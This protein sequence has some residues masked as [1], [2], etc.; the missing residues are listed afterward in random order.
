MA[1]PIGTPLCCWN[2]T[3]EH[4]SQSQALLEQPNHPFKSLNYTNRFKNITVMAIL[5]AQLYIG[6]RKDLPGRDFLRQILT[7]F[8]TFLKK[9]LR[10]RNFIYLIGK[11]KN[12]ALWNRKDM[13]HG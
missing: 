2:L 6:A 8:G 5:A 13:G 12:S 11:P 10:Y 3:F 1:A 4:F 7:G 9:Y